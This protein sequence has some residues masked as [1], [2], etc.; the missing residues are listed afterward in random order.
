M[1]NPHSRYI[2][3]ILRIAPAVF[4]L[5]LFGISLWAI[6]GQL[7]QYRLQDIVQSV[8]AIP[9]ARVL[10][11]L[12]FV[13]SNIV[14]MTWYD[15]LAIRHMQQSLTYR[16][17]ALAAVLSSVISNNVGFALLANGALRYRFYSAWG[18]S[19]LQVAK[20]TAFCNLSFGLGQMTVGGIV[21]LVEPP[22]LPKVLHFPVSVHLLG[23]GCLSVVALYLAF[24]ALSHKSLRLWKWRIPQVPLKV[25]FAQLAIASL[26]WLLAAAIFYALLPPTASLSYSSFLGIYLLAQAAGVLSNIPGGLGVFETA[27][28]LSLSPLMSSSTLVGAL[29][30]FRGLYYILP[31]MLAVLALG[32]YEIQ[33]KRTLRIRKL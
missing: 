27:M 8:R 23:A 20:L 13:F 21:F 25:S 32:L 12:S 29:L 16:K 10:L 24:S 5:A 14:V 26:D 33:R 1:G 18:F 9:R 31:L 6:Y 15:A 28:L 4:S 19:T 3:W 2:K 17:T 30:A 7:H 22:F 11:A